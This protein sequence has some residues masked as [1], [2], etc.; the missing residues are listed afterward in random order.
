MYRVASCHDKHDDKV[1]ARFRRDGTDN[2]DD[3]GDD[4]NDDDNDDDNDYDHH[5]DYAYDYDYMSGT[6][7]MTTTTMK[8]TMMRTTTMTLPWSW[9]SPVRTRWHAITTCGMAASA[10]D[11]RR[12]GE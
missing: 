12:G 5:D 4:N 7:T 6:M 3:D 10:R 1:M 9:Y 8:T 11:G 2:D